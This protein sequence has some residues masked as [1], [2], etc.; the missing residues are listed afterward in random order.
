M[1]TISCSAD[2]ACLAAQTW[3]VCEIE[4]LH[5][6]ADVLHETKALEEA[7]RLYQDILPE[8]D[9]A[10]RPDV[11]PAD[12]SGPGPDR[13]ALHRGRARRTGAVIETV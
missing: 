3:K 1:R 11:E 5:T 6:L 9:S 10:G 4:T 8:V 7:L 12:G 2:V 13:A